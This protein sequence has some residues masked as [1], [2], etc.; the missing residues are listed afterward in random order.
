MRDFE[1]YG[2]KINQE[3]A[4]YIKELLALGYEHKQILEIIPFD[5]SIEIINN[6]AV[7]RSWKNM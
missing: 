1:K 3:K 6:I 7:G 4:G 2:R 5:C